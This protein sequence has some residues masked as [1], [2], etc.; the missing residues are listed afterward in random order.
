[1]LRASP[2]GRDPPKTCQRGKQTIQGAARKGWQ[3]QALKL[4]PVAPHL[5]SCGFPGMGL[6][7]AGGGF[8]TPQT[9]K[10]GFTCA[11]AFPP[12]THE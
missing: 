4:P 3:T 9:A 7:G 5:A 10:T 2:F 1:M 12:H 6:A 11:T 8:L